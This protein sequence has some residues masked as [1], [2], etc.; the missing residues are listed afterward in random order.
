[1]K[2]ALVYDYLNQYGGGERVLEVLINI[3][4]Q[5]D[6]Y[7]LF[8]DSKKTFNKFPEKRIKQ[9]S[10]LNKKIISANHHFFIPLMPKAIES[11]NLKD[12][13]DLILSIGAGYS[14]GIT[15][16]GSY[17]ISYCFTPLRYAWE[18]TNYLK[19]KFGPKKYLFLKPILSPLI[20][21]LRNW[22]KRAGQKPDEIIS[23]SNF[24]A[25][26]VKKYYRRQSKIIYPPV[27][28]RKFYPE[29]PYKNRHYFLAVGR[30][31]HYKGFDLIIKAFNELKLPLKILG[32]GPELKKLRKLNKSSQTSFISYLANDEEM[33]EIY[34][35]AKAL[36]FPQVEDFG[37]VAVEALSCGTPVIAYHAG[38]SLEI[39]ENRKNG[40]F[41]KDQTSE[42]IIEA[43]NQVKEM[44]FNS[45][46]ISKTVQKFSEEKFKKEILK[47]INGF[48]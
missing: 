26:K 29:I 48:V 3:F 41:I 38:G 22:D 23:I 2:I 35:N 7:T 19:N 46:E 42:S 33:R 20:Y 37:L 17:H 24:I 11:L 39:I 31:I 8:F 34:N 14:K 45:S 43:V 18:P 32:R 6:I 4:P 47:I 1:M 13:Y 40:L 25:S 36:I 21:Y 9:T 10:F 5:A 30:L 15:Y 44:E 28:T 12:K 16:H 27:N